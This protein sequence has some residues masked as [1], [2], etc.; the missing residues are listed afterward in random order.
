MT[1]TEPE[2]DHIPRL[3]PGYTS[4]L[5]YALDCIDIRSLELESL[6]NGDPTFSRDAVRR[7]AR[8]E[9]DELRNKAAAPDK[10]LSIS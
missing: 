9:L 7:A 2:S 8:Q 1:N 10:G 3:P 4:W 6:F 5:D